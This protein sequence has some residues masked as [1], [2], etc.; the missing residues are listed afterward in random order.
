MIDLS[1]IGIIRTP[2][3]GSAGSPIQPKFAAGIEGR[4]EVFEE[5]REGL[6]D[7]D[8]FERIWIVF[9]CDRA[10]P[11]RLKIVPYRDTVKRGLFSTRSPSR[12]N[13]IGISVVKL[14]ETNIGEGIL[15]VDGVDMLDRTP[16]LDL[17]PYVPEFDSFP[18]SKAG[19]LNRI[20]RKTN[21]ADNRFQQS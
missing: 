14:V 7:L 5:F 9:W 3:T 4:I 2:F 17:K 12:P 20:K 8:R 11:Y 15:A 16:L 1:P 13:P 18:D 10:K 21:S 19:W 6:H